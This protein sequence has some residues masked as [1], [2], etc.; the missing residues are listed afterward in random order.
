L[1]RTEELKKYIDKELPY[2][3]LMHMYENSRASLKSL[4]RSLGVTFPTVAR[5]LKELEQK[6]SIVYTLELSETALGFTEGR[7]ITIKFENAPDIDMLKKRFTNDIF[8]Q[9]MYLASGNF[10]LLMYV[11]GLTN[12]D[13]IAWQFKLREDLGTYKPSLKIATADHFSIGFFPLRNEL[14]DESKALSEIEKRILK[15][16]NDNSRMKLGDLIKKSHSTQM[17]VIYTIKKLQ[18]RGIIKRFTALT[19]NPDKRILLAFTVLLTP[20]KKHDELV[21]KFLQELV[22]EDLHEATNDYCI[23]VDTV[24]AYDILN[25]NTFEKGETVP[26]RGPD[27]VQSLWISEDCKIEMAILTDLLIGKYPFH[28]EKYTRQHGFIKEL[29]RKR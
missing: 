23:V 1:P 3:I 15:L 4:G 7:V 5:T 2:N 8:V 12:K 29:G 20:T 13:F 6:Y 18:E 17:R 9:E 24:G 10:D 22:K 25:I 11:V 21:L 26:K 19:Q 28:L 16:L 14:I 27:L